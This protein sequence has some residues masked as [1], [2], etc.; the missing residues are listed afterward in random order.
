MHRVVSQL[1]AIPQAPRPPHTPPPRAYP[2]PLL[3][4][5][6]NDKPIDYFALPSPGLNDALPEIK[7]V[8]GL[9]MGAADD[10]AVE[11]A[12]DGSVGRGC[13]KLLRAYRDLAEE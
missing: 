4:P 2:G 12:A 11:T 9:R 6:V 13:D 5:M 8:L 10:S 3:V 1:H 7:V